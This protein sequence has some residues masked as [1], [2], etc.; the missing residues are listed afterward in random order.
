MDKLSDVK[1]EKV[2]IADDTSVQIGSFI[3]EL[4]VTDHAVI[5]QQS[6]CKNLSVRINNFFYYP[7]DS[8]NTISE[9]VEIAAVPACA[10]WLKTSEAMQF[11]IDVSA[12]RL[13][14]THDG[15][16]NDTGHEFTNNW[17]KRAADQSKKDITFL[18][19][20]ESILSQ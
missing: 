10:P 5:W 15:M 12:D 7:G 3:V 20:G 14:T 9:K 1:C 17:L 2:V 18:K 13:I 19:N 4:R 6:P 16:L 8:L 11:I